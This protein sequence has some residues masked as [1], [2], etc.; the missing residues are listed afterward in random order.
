MNLFQAL[1]TP[2]LRSVMAQQDQQTMTI[3]KMYDVTTTSQREGKDSKK[4]AII[5][6]VN[7]DLDFQSEPEEDKNDV[8]GFGC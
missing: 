7:E 1:L 3:R 5:N 8:A 6:E 4:L 2:E